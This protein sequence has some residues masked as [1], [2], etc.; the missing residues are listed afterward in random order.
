MK[1][2]NLVLFFIGMS[3]VFY[4]C[5]MDDNSMKDKDGTSYKTIKIGDQIWM[6]ENLDYYTPNGS[7]S[8]NDKPENSERFGRLYTWETAC[9]VCPDGWH[10]P[11]DEEWDQL[12]IFL[13]NNGNNSDGKSKDNKIAISLASTT[14]WKASSDTASVGYNLSV[15][16]SSGFTALPGGYRYY[17]GSFYNLGNMGI[18]WS[19]SKL[20]ISEEVYRNAY[21]INNKTVGK[22]FVSGYYGASVRCVKDSK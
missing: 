12:I 15:N 14:E 22:D 3:F 17:D 11:S 7:W 1:K 2:R 8:Y 6:A 4:N 19:S 10:L 13:I 16:N 20:P 5:S 18:W 9:T 21:Y